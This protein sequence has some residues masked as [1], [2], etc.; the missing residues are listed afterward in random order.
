MPA[1][2]LL[3]VSDLHLDGAAPQAIDQFGTFLQQRAMRAAALYILGD[4]FESWVGDDDDE[5]SRDGVCR[6]L[7]RY[8]QAGRPCYV[9]RGNRDFLLG[10]GFEQRTGCVLLPDPVRIEA[11]ALKLVATHGDPL[12]TADHSYQQFR[13]MVRN[14]DWQARYLQLPLAMRHALADAARSG[15]RR[16]TGRT[17]SYIMDVAPDAVAAAFRVGGCDLLVH[18][19]TH[20]PAIHEHEVDGRRCTRIVLGDW[21]DQGSLLTLEMDGTW[22]LESLPRG[23]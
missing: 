5:P 21:Y 1:D 13:S 10:A 3:F 19:H 15:S 7:R 6:A 9:L 12:C 11:G 14:L 8:T 4:L 22:N 18:G 16:H 23:P 20:R 2:P 17:Q